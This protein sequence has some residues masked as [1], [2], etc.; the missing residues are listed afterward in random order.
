MSDFNVSKRRFGKS[1]T[2]CCINSGFAVAFALALFT[3]SRNDCYTIKG[4]STPV[5]PEVYPDAN[6]VTMWFNLTCFI[7][8]LFY[9]LGAVSSLGYSAKTGIIQKYAGW[10]E[11]LARF[12]TY[13]VFIAV[14]IMR[15]SHTGAVCSG[16]YLPAEARSDPNITVNYM[17]PTGKFFMFYIILGWVMVPTLLIIMVCIKG[18]QW[19]ALALDSPK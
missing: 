3:L 17:I 7:G 12:T 10:L 14:H 16:D 6:N 13:T 18:D 8:F 1:A 5:D 19:A 2:Y 15:F 11:K 4:T 9:T